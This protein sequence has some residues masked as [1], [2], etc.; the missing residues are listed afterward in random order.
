MYFFYIYI[1]LCF[2]IIIHVNPMHL[3]ELLNTNYHEYKLM[4]IRILKLFAK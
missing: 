4:K 2:F 1:N 3:F